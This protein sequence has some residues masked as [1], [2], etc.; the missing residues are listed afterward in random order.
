MTAS[1]RDYV[2]RTLGESARL[3]HRHVAFS[4]DKQLQLAELVG[5]LNWSFNKP[6]GL[7]SFGDRYKWHVQILGTEAYGR[8]TWLWAWA[9]Q[10]SNIPAKQLEAS[11]TMKALGEEQAITEFTTPELPLGEIN[12]HMLCLIA[13]GVCKANAYYRGPYTGGAAFFLIQDDGFPKRKVVPLARIVSVFPQV[14]SALEM[15]GLHEKARFY[16]R[17]GG[18]G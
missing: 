10:A 17:G 7:L 1:G 18:A 13:S 2:A 15:P 3:F 12:G 9:N 16:R 6:T 4:F 5:Q 14:I 8:N 11:M